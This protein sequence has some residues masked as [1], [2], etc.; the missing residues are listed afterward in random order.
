MDQEARTIKPINEATRLVI[1]D[2]CYPHV[3]PVTS[4]ALAFETYRYTPDSRIPQLVQ[5][6]LLGKL[7]MAIVVVAK[8]PDYDAWRA[9]NPEALVLNIIEMDTFTMARTLEQIG[10]YKVA[11]KIGTY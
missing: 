7:R 9:D 8:G 11:R 6:R 5:K 1:M 4:T 2:V 3:D 10:L